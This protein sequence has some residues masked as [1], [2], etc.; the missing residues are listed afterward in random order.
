MRIHGSAPLGEWP[1]LSRG[2]GL[3]RAR[4]AGANHRKAL[5]CTPLSLSAHAT[6]L[7]APLAI[8][9]LNSGDPLDVSLATAAFPLRRGFPSEQV[10]TA[11][12]GRRALCFTAWGRIEAE[13]AS[14]RGEVAGHDQKGGAGHGCSK[15]SQTSYSAF[16]CAV[17][18]P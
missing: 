18:S 2:A 8:F 11:A 9:M 6:C 7:Q 10:A 3:F 14:W 1:R 17:I 5:R 15:A 16:W 13:H 12:V 4:D